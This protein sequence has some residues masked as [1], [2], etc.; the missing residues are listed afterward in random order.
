MKFFFNQIKG[1]EI[2]AFFEDDNLKRVN[3]DGSAHTIYYILD[4]EDA[5]TGMNKTICSEM[6]LY[7]GNNKIENIHY[8]KKPTGSYIPL[9]KVSSKDYYLEGFKWEINKKPKSLADLY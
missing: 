5:Y 8:Y 1:K 9:D 3:V 4:E 7:F 6:L 2:T